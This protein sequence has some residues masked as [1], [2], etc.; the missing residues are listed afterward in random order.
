MLWMLMLLLEGAYAQDVPMPA[1]RVAFVDGAIADIKDAINTLE[2][3][4]TQAGDDK[5]FIACLKPKLPMMQILLSISEQSKIDMQK[6]VIAG[7][8][9]QADLEM[10]KINVAQTKAR[11]FLDQAYACLPANG[12]TLVEVH[13]TGPTEGVVDIADNT[14]G[15]EDRF[16]I[17][18]DPTVG[19]PQ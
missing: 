7:D 16:I 18:T 2:K 12:R 1:D 4:I 10:R 3:L 5:E 17:P 6:A 14:L 8:V 15:L 13:M 9:G 19:T 11:E